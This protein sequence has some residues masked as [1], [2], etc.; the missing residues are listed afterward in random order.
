MNLGTSDLKNIA[1]FINAVDAAS[2]AYGVSI[3]TNVALWIEGDWVGRMVP[4]EGVLV[5]DAAGT[6]D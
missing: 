3:A 6:D 4:E 2:Q 5:F 1:G